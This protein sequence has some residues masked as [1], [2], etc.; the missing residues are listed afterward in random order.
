MD[1]EEALT[2][3]QRIKRGASMRKN[4]GK[5]A[6]SKEKNSKKLAPKE[7]LVKRSLIAA[8]KVMAKKLAG[9]KDVS[10]LSFSERERIEKA[11]AKKKG[12]IKA[13]AKKLFKDIMAKEKAKFSK[14]KE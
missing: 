2:A 11:L 3:S 6:R 7:V 13:L 1:I 8:R 4:K 9:G 12:K 10:G 14:D 5:I